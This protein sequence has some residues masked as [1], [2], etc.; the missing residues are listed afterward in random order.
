VGDYETGS[1]VVK[2]GLSAGEVVVSQG[3]KFLRQGEVVSSDK[4]AAK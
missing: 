2:S 1:F 4:D 3:T